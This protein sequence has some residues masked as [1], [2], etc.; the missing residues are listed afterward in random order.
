MQVKDLCTIRVGYSFRSRVIDDPEGTT[1][2]VQ[3]K[4]ISSDGTISFNGSTLLRTQ[5]TPRSPLKNGE[6]LVLNKGHFA[7]AVFD[8][9]QG[10]T[11]VTT[12]SVMVITLTSKEVIPEYI[13]LYLN[14]T[15]GQRK[16]SSLQELSSIPF[17]KR[18]NIEKM[19][20]PVPS[21]SKQKKLVEMN[22]AISNYTELTKRKTQILK[23]LMNSEL[24]I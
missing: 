4:N 9:P 17:V 6:V 14:S 8:M 13:A 11:W 15:K 16:L 10:E 22:N 18:K 1:K 24:E 20:I 2:I 23:N 5:V 19:E 7:A 12:A 21:I 3:P